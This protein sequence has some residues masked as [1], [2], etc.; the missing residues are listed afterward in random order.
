LQTL[1]T[2]LGNLEAKLT[3]AVEPD[4]KLRQWPNVA[5]QYD[6]EEEDLFKCTAWCCFVFKTCPHTIN[7]LIKIGYLSLKI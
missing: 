4:V 2:I 3:G 5:T 1:K 7:A 6:M